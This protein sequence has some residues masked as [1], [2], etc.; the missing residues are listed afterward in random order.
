MCCDITAAEIPVNVPKSQAFLP[1]F[2]LRLEKKSKVC[3]LC[4]SS[5][6]LASIPSGKTLPFPVSARIFNTAAPR[7]VEFFSKKDWVKP[8]HFL[9]S[10]TL[11]RIESLVFESPTSESISPHHFLISP[12]LLRIESLVFE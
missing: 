2:A 3:A 7:G 5:A 1:D 9:I 4:T 10:L 11:L 6:Q 12:T 8:H